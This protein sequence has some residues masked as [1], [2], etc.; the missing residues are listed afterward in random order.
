MSDSFRPVDSFKEAVRFVEQG[1]NYEKTRRWKYNTRYLNLER[2]ERLLEAI[3]NPHRR[4]RIAHIAG[5]KGKGSTAGAVAHVLRA[6][7]CRTGLYSKPH[8]VTPRERVRVDGEMIREEEFTR[9]VRAMQPHVESKR[10]EEAE[11]DRAPTYFE[12]LTA[13]AFHTFAEREVDWAVVEVGLGGRLD[14]TNVVQPDCCAITAIGFDHTD[15]LGETAE[16]IAGEKAGILKEGVPVVIGRQQYPGALETLRRVAEERECPRWEVGRELR[17]LH[18][19]PAVAPPE[20]PDAPVGWRF[21]LETPNRSYPELFCPMAGRHQVD[22]LAAAVGVV[23]LAAARTDLQM[24]PEMVAQALGEHRVPARVEILRRR[25]AFVVDVAH[26]VESVQ[27]LVD[28]LRLHLPDRPMRFVFACSRGK[29]AAGM[30]EVLRPHCASFVAAQ[31][32]SPRAVPAEEIARTARELGFEEKVPE[33]VR[34]VPDAVAAVR[35]ELARA[36]PDEI[37]CITGSFLTTGQARAWWAETH[38][39]IED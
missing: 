8:L 33:G 27:A 24:P 21:G 13:V 29:N 3:G 18:A 4:Y 38:P 19:E 9:N 32:E 31:A 39:G 7:G 1:I 35:G 14:S 37:V 26:T 34:V 30:L 5:T 17:V 36:E 28:A 22:N 6:A 16:A 11:A 23:E 12:M 15:K 10:G 20:Q 25:P 2:M